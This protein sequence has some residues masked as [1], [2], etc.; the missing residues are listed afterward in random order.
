[1]KAGRWEDRIDDLVK[2]GF[3]LRYNVAPTTNVPVW[4]AEGQAAMHW[5]LIPHWAPE[6]KMTYP[7]FNARVESVAEKSSFRDPWRKGQRCLLPALG[8]YEWRDDGGMRQPYFIHR[9]DNE[10]MAFAGLWE[11]WEK[12]GTEV[13]SC[14]ILTG[15]SQGPLKELHHRMPF[16]LEPEAAEAWLN[17][18]K[19]DADDVLA[20][21]RLDA[22]AF[23][24]VSSAVGNV[25]N[26]DP[27]LIEPAEVGW[28]DLWSQQQDS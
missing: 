17:G 8:Y 21:P 13:F 24:R 27:I 22:V 10:L 9:S 6:A 15:E 4:L 14:T 11:R 3:D 23:H 16:M 5:G 2:A 18:S 25:R 19:A 28:G 1:M 12:G 20:K 7:T 26:N